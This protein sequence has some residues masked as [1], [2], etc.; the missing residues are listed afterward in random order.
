MRIAFIIQRYGAEV[1]G[2]AETLAR[3]VAE[4][5]APFMQVEVITTC[6]SDQDWEN[7]YAPGDSVVNNIPVHRFATDHPR[8]PEFSR[9]YAELLANPKATVLDEIEWMKAQGPHSSDLLHFLRHHH[10]RYDLLVFVGYLFFHT[11]FG[12]QV[13]PHKSILIPTTHDEPPLYFNIFNTVFS[14][15]RGLI[16]LTEEERRLAHARFNLPQG[17]RQAVIGGGI[18]IPHVTEEARA[19]FRNKYNINTPYVLYAGQISSSKGCDTLFAW[20]TRFQEEQHADVKLI[21][22]GRLDMKMPVHGA[23]TYLGMLSD[24]EKFTAMSGARVF[25]MPSHLESF[26]ISSLEAWAS[27]TPIL[28]NAAGQVLKSHCIRSNG[29]LFYDSYLVFTE[30][31]KLMLARADLRERLGQNGNAYV[32]ANYDWDV[33]QQRY[34]SFIKAINR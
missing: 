1:L 28:V 2:G 30:C 19:A 6:A 10:D 32:R 29:G 13:A 18:H 31:L 15:P 16:Y 7:T 5:L 8:H 33:I 12:L 34:H 14:L 26:S 24:D 17:T 21:C 3:E 27:G 11:Y 20:F 4:R 22:I 25:V 23:V 9:I